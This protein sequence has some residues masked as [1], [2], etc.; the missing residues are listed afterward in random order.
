[1]ALT[2]VYLASAPGG[3]AITSGGKSYSANSS[4]VITAVL[5]LDA[6]SLQ[7]AGGGPLRLLCATGATTDRP[8]PQPATALTGAINDINPLPEPGLRFYDTTL[9]DTVYFVGTQNCSTGWVNHTGAA[10]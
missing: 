7:S 4:G 6:L 3:L 9:S 2:Y 10:G 8:A 1:M 5:P